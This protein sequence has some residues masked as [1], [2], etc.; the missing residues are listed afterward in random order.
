MIITNIQDKKLDTKLEIVKLSPIDVVTKHLI[1]DILQKVN[2]KI[3]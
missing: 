3:Q 1:E 2:N